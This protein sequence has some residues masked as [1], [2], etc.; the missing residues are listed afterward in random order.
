MIKRFNEFINENIKHKDINEQIDEILDSLSKSGELSKSEKEFMDEASKGTIKDLT[1]PSPTGN[2]WADMANPHN[3]GIMW[4]GEDGV[5]KQLKSLEDEEYDKVDKIKDSDKR[6]E[7]RKELEQKKY[8]KL[9]P[10]LRN[11]LLSLAKSL[12]NNSKKGISMNANKLEKMKNEIKDFDTRYQFSSK[13]EYA[14]KSLYSLHNQFGYILP[15]LVFDDEEG[16][17]ILKN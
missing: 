3:L 12:K 2:F 17:F 8:L 13:I 1:M 16:E 4:L 15:E 9:L 5:W 6:W 11:V 7:K 14:V 10:N